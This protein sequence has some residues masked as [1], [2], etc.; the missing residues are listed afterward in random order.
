MN[1]TTRIGTALSLAA[2]FSLSTAA[3]SAQGPDDDPALT[4]KSVE[5]PERSRMFVGLYAI[6]SGENN[7]D[8]IPEERLES[9]VVRITQEMIVVLDGEQNALYSCTYALKGGDTPQKLDMEST[10]GPA[11][12]VGQQARG[13]ITRGTNDEGNPFV[14]LCYR[15]LGDSYP[16]E[17]TTEAQSETILFVLKPIPDPTE[18]DAEDDPTR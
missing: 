18:V 2:S 1:T 10:G 6:M 13:I 15:T 11:D 9:H 3:A 5:D 14:M 7:G 16:E 17:F 12:A 4:A 8:P